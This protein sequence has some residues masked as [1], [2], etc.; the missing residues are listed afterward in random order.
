MS[1][2]TVTVDSSVIDAMI[3][4]WVYVCVGLVVFM[5]VGV[6][7]FL[8]DRHRTP[9]PSKD[10]KSAHIQKKPM[11]LLAGLDHIADLLLLNRF[12]PEVLEHIVPSSLLNKKPKRVMRFALPQKTKIG[13]VEVAEGKDSILTQKVIQWLNEMATQKTYLRGVNMPIFVGVQNRAIAASFPLGGALNF[14][15]DQEIILRNYKVVDAMEQS[16]D[17]SI[18]ELA[19]VMK[20][21]GTGVS[22]VDFHAV[23]THIDENWDLTVQEGISERDRTDGR[24][25]RSED[26]DKPTKTI[27]LLILGIIGV[28]IAGGIVL[29]VITG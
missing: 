15:K 12:I 19:A 20:R 21:Q 5:I 1:L 8:W 10:L 7:Y 14:L 25:E 3:M 29:K 11:I 2:P 16:K 22:M 24:L 18:R 28:I 23:A 26:K 6:V 9:K 4:Q 27:L 13:E 17:S